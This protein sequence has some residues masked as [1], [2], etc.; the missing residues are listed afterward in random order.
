MRTRSQIEKA[1]RRLGDDRSAAWLRCFVHHWRDLP[2]TESG[3]HY[4]EKCFTMW[5]PKDGVLN[6]PPKSEVGL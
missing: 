6:S 1:A 2:V 3:E 5:T 4:C